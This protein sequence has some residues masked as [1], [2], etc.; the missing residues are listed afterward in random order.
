M[1]VETVVTGD[2]S[3]IPRRRLA[4]LARRVLRGEKGDLHLTL[5]FAG[6]RLLRALNRRFRHIDR[7]TDVLSF[8]LPALPPAIP[9]AGEI[10]VSVEQARRQAKRYRHSLAAELERLVVHG[11]LHLLGYDHK[12]KAEA[13]RMR[14]RE[15]HYVTGANR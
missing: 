12:R 11:V 2:A 14:I 4:L 10:Y 15:A 13:A 1:K 3:D 9:A 7:T 6:D 8:A 5:V